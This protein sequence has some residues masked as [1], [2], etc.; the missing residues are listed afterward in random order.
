MVTF[1]AWVLAGSM[2][3]SIVAP[4]NLLC[5]E[6]DEPLATAWSV[7]EGLS[8]P[9]S[10]CYDPASNSI[11]VSNI[12]GKAAEKDGAGWIS[13]LDSTGKVVE[14]QWV[15]GLNAPKGIGVH[16]NRLWVSDI[17][18]LIGIDI[19]TGEIKERIPLDS[20]KFL[21]DVAIDHDGVVY[22]SDMLA[23][24][25]F[26]VADGK[27]TVAAEGEELSFPNGILV[28]DGKLIIASRGEGL[29]P[30]TF[31]AKAPGHLLSL[32]L[33][34]KEIEPI[35]REPLGFLDGVELDGSG[36]Y[37][38]SDVISGKLFRVTSE[39]EAA[40]LIENLNKPADF[41]VIESERLLVLPHLAAN[42][43]VAYRL[44]D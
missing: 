28:H 11:F 26:R 12:A 21:N 9:E 43:V 25:I 31:V 24:K 18:Q 3:I 33:S 14:A 13:K 44:S 5:A 2:A 7:D 42:K 23:N 10:A 30:Q 16:K 38:V 37:Y 8:A 17:D 40:L 41:A 36:G 22:V 4:L 15:R 29:D 34:T 20:A 1:K 35:T 32:D 6:S 27:A 39:G 19:P